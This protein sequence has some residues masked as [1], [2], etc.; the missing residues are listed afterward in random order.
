MRVPFAIFKS[1]ILLS[2]RKNDVSNL[3]GKMW[4]KP[5]KV[6]VHIKDVTVL[7]HTEYIN[8]ND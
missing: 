1:S 2:N 6:D 3:K 4:N 8:Y 7:Y 5:S